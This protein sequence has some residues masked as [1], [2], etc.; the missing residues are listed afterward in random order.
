MVSLIN[1]ARIQQ[2]KQPIGFLNP[3][4]YSAGMNSSSFFNDV[5]LG[6]NHCCA[7]DATPLCCNSGFNA[8]SGWD[9]VT[10]RFLPLFFI[11]LIIYPAFLLN[12]FLNV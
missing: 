3:S 7:H 12:V 5:V 6:N 11:F 10:G 9:P 8:T 4:L 1:S 2:N